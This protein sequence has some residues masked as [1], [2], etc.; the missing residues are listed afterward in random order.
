[1][2]NCTYDPKKLTREQIDDILGGN[3]RI[4]RKISGIREASRPK[5]A[6]EKKPFLKTVYKKKKATPVAKKGVK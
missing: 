6:R 2:S 1:M 5:R 3:V 4:N